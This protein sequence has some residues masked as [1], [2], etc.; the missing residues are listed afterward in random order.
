[1]L[2]YGLSIHV[3]LSN[4][5][6]QYTVYNNSACPAVVQIA[7]S[8]LALAF[9]HGKLVMV[10]VVCQDRKVVVAE[11]KNR[12]EQLQGASLQD[13]RIA[14]EQQRQVRPAHCQSH[15]PTACI[16]GFTSYTLHVQVTKWCPTSTKGADWLVC[17]GL[18][19]LSYSSLNTTFGDA[20][21]AQIIGQAHPLVGGLTV[22]MHGC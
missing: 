12:C 17:M 1:M 22:N 16:H 19:S 20:L 18:C 8:A 6:E 14:D 9:V 11:A 2:L 21:I 4:H 7:S 10:Q 13:K 15:Y 3:S 5:A